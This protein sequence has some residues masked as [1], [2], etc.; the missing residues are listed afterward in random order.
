M[1]RLIALTIVVCAAASAQDTAAGF[2]LS[3]TV[4]G[5]GAASSENGGSAGY[6]AV[7]YPMLKLGDRWSLIGAYQLNSADG[8]PGAT[9]SSQYR[10]KGYLLQG[11][12]N[13]AIVRSQSSL[14]LRVGEMSTSFGSFP[15]RYDDFQN[16]LIGAPAQYGYYYAPVSTPG[17]PGIQADAT[18]KR[19]DFRAQVTNSS[20]AN[21]RGLT[22]ADQYL[23]ETGG[24]G[25]TIRQGF[26]VGASVYHGPYLDRHSRFYF[27]GEAPPAA[28]K[29]HAEGVDV[30]WAAGHWCL[31]G[32][33][34]KFTFPY[35]TIPTFR[36]QTGYVEGKRVLN[37]RWYVASR[38]GYVSSGSGWD[39]TV[40]LVGGFRPAANALLKFGYQWRHAGGGSDESIA[41]AQFSIAL[42]P[43]SRA[44]R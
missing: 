21:P 24:A 4:S 42:H 33:W 32:E 17:I 44:F 30:Q 40:E 26:R 6:R 35:K 25:Y 22:A 8:F 20:P 39:E 10:A 34:Q 41:M 27:P 36:E 28:L 7:L 1:L 11:T 23:N 29:A 14:V 19:I 5:T 38:A 15:L 3:I 37:P 12:L 16:P 2:D 13:Y 9:P 18:W 43:V 31:Q